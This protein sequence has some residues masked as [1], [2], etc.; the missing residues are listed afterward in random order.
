MKKLLALAL[1]VFVLC[2][3]L[4][5]GASAAV[6]TSDA[7]YNV[8]VEFDTDGFI[9]MTYEFPDRPGDFLWVD[10]WVFEAGTEP[11]T[12]A[13]LA[14][15]F[16]QGNNGPVGGNRLLKTA[17]DNQFLP[18]ERWI[19]PSFDEG[20]DSEYTFENGKTYNI[21]FGCCDGATWFYFTKPYVLQYGDTTDTPSDVPSNVP[22]DDA[23]ND[24]EQESTA[25]V[26]VIAYAAVA[27]TGLGALVIG[28]RK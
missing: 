22:S 3:F 17:A 27:I 19:G 15:L 11:A 20:A 1:T 23:G 9:F 21:Y 24:D 4:S 13:E 10:M 5:I 28:K 7:D 25:D 6:T 2:S 26:S 12:G 14:E 16:M 18:T 8:T